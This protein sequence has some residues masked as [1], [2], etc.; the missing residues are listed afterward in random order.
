MYSKHHSISSKTSVR[1]GKT[2]GWSRIGHQLEDLF[3]RLLDFLSTL[4]HVDLE[5]VKTLM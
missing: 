2:K 1:I 5:I 3:M 4:P